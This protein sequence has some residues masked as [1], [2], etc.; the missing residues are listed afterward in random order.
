MGAA[1]KAAGP[2]LLSKSE[3]ATEFGMARATISKAIDDL[4]IRP[5]D[6]RAGYDVYRLAD[7]IQIVKVDLSNDGEVRA[8][9]PSDILALARADE[10]RTDNALKQL[11]LRE[12]EADLVRKNAAR[13]EMANMIKPI[14]QLLDIIPDVLERD[15]GI[16]PKAV[17]RCQEVLER[18]KA[19][20]AKQ[21]ES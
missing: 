17:V 5:A 2:I 4:G 13:L 11:K 1:K 18:E 8:S 19:H 14:I 12:Q 20:L 10:S 21:L 3:A 15:C 6:R 7:L 16:S 9:K